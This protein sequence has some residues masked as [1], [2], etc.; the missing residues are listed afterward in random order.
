YDALRLYG[1]HSAGF[2]AATSIRS[3]DADK[4]STP[5]DGANTRQFDDFTLTSTNGLINGMWLDHYTAINRANIVLQRIANDQSPLTSEAVKLSGQAE[6]RF[7]RAYAYFMLVRYFG[8]VP[9]IDSIATDQLSS[10][11]VP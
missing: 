2:Q 11:N 4:G 1:V 8:G 3:D 10:A 7:I 5:S 6:A 9:L